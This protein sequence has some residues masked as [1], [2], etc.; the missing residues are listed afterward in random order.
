MIARTKADLHLHTTASDGTW[1]VGDLIRVVTDAGIH[2]FSITDH[3]AIASA[4][5]VSTMVLPSSLRFIR[6]VE[7]TAST[8]LGRRH[9]LGYQYDPENPVLTDL[10]DHNTKATLRWFAQA[11]EYARS[12]F[13]Q[14]DMTAFDA[15]ENNRSRGGCKA[16]NYLID[17]K[18][19]ASDEEF[20]RLIRE[21]ETVPDFADITDVIN[22]IHGAAVEFWH[23]TQALAVRAGTRLCAAP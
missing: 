3:D 13:D 4:R 15:Y 14:I 6:G 19:V 21:S 20:G 18:A 12:R 8:G 11:V 7:V 10:L 1:S 5:A 9:I 2:L 22:A 23:A 17:N 16:L